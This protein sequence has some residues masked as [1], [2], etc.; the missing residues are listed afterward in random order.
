MTHRRFVRGRPT[1]ALVVVAAI[2]LTGCSSGTSP[3]ELASAVA[4]A[5]AAS[6]PPVASEAPTA[7]SPEASSTAA[8]EEPSETALPSAVATDIDPCQLITQDEASSFV[9]V[10]FAAGK[11]SDTD[12]NVKMCS[13]AGPGPNIFSVEVAIA[14]DE[15]TAKAAEAAQEKD[16]DAQAGQLADLNLSVTKL[17]GFADDTDAAILQGS[18]AQGPIAVDARAMFVLRGTTFFA[19]SDVAVNGK[20]PSEQKFRDKAMELLGKVP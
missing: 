17:P 14:P 9:G 2:A 12:K 19:F 8:S 10:K 1:G 3:S 18:L 7:S 5:I 4:S 6:P 20:A 16:L 13:Y 15:A 11:E